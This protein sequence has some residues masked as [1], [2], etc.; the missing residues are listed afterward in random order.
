[1]QRD[2]D[3]QPESEDQPERETPDRDASPRDAFA[4]DPWAIDEQQADAREPTPSSPLD[5]G[6]SASEADPATIQPDQP[7]GPKPL[8]ARMF[9]KIGIPTRPGV[10]WVLDWIQVLVIAGILAWVVMN[11]GIVRM[12][13]PTGSME[14]TIMPGDSFFVDKFTYLLGVNSPE[15][16][17]IIVF[18]HTD[19]SRMCPENRL[20]YWSWGKL[21]PCKERYVKRLIAEGPAK[22]AI[23]QGDVYV[24]GELRDGPAFDRD[25]VCRA[26]APRNPEARDAEGCSWDVPDGKMFVLGDNT[27]NSSDS[28][29]WGFANV[30]TLIGEPFF[31][32]WPVN[33]IGP[34]NGYF[35]S[36]R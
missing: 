3:R 16:G 7:Q 20:L 4:Q 12:R 26:G 30:S 32:V 1:M 19:N 10:D 15:P 9:N 29:Y 22:V 8:L 24:D 21:E 18:W 34:M 35:G 14:P 27:R 36:G 2:D 13:V 6:D 25:Y 28:R 23:R 11:Y 5:E 31:R 33:R 17:D